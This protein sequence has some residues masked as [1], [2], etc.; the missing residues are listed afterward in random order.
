MPR[1]RGGSRR[2]R[3][4]ITIAGAVALATSAA[5]LA[6]AGTGNDPPDPGGETVGVLIDRLGSADFQ[7]RE[8]AA[9]ELQAIG[10][11]AVDALLAAA[12]TATDLEIALRARW[13]VEAIPL[14]MPHDSPE[15]GRLLES[16]NGRD[17]DRR[18]R[19]MHRLLRLDDDAGI[20]ALAR[21]VRLERSPEGAQLA[22]ALLA[23]EWRPG[24][25]WWPAIGRHAL[26]GLGR[27]RRPAAGFVRALV[28]FSV[29]DSA[30]SR[31]A[32][33][34]AAAEAL[35][36]L[37]RP[38]G[39]VGA[40]GDA[41]AEAEVDD[42]VPSRNEG[43]NARQTL[44]RCLARMLLAE[45]R[46]DEALALVGRHLDGA[47]QA[48][49]TKQAASRTVDWLAWATEAGIPEIVDRIE[50][51]EPGLPAAEPLV[52]WAA[53]AAWRA[54]GNA[55]RAAALADASFAAHR[56]PAPGRDILQLIQ[57]AIFL[58]RQ[59]CEEWAVRCY[60]AVLADPRSSMRE[61]AYTA[62][63]GAEY[64][65]ELGR[66]EEAAA[67]LGRL[68]A[69][70]PG[71]RDVNAEQVLGEI[72][73]DH[74][75]VL[76]RM[77]YFASCAAATRGDRVEQR[78]LLENALREQ[79]KEI[80]SLIALHGLADNTPDQQA[81]ARRRVNEA[82]RQIENEIHSLPEEP[83]PLNEWAWLAANT[84]GDAEKATRYSK[85]SLVKSFDSS[86]YLDTLAH[87]RA[88]AGDVAG[89]LRWQTL[90]VRQEPHNVMIRKNLSRFEALAGG[91]A[92]PAR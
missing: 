75:A 77:Q 79:G 38:P 69:P 9:A 80:D 12:E 92:E 40:E 2:A 53:A 49:N 28:E 8:T 19:V 88:A 61:Y 6:G 11:A 74:R 27:S 81:D 46:R 32:A 33:L 55:D 89:A 78:R 76:A 83:N 67:F 41:E 37:E 5:A 17:L 54:R 66:D 47:R 3:R 73:R 58:A 35:D 52:G 14:E 84:G 26:V 42:L 13:I 25:R 91:A 48:T 59:G 39:S 20:E 56:R 70:G 36:A 71:Q 15:V 60:Q 10:P 62:V 16:Y 1:G 68:F 21:I 65:H 30:E 87:C 86:S 57:A 45:G 51:A 29:A 50:A 85:Q 24:D 90:A 72:D 4:V 7:T 64:L 18:V 31:G 22:A 23:R 82:L 63:M 44:V 34:A 43:G